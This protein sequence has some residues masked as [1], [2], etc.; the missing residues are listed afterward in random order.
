MILVDGTKRVWD[1]RGMETNMRT[2]DESGRTRP[3]TTEEQAQMLDEEADFYVRYNGAKADEHRWVQSL[4]GGADRLRRSLV[5]AQE[6]SAVYA[7]NRMLLNR[8]ERTEEAECAMAGAV[9]AMA[10]DDVIFDYMEDQIVILEEALMAS[11]ERAV[12]AEWLVADMRDQLANMEEALMA[13]I[14]AAERE[15]DR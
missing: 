13:H 6:M 7:E 1:N 8:A 2:A 12:K 11:D 9:G 15:R 5:T 4:R 3:M 10:G 14:S